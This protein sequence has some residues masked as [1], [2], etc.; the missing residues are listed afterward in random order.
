MRGR[1]RLI[2]VLLAGVLVGST[3]TLAVQSRGAQADRRSVA[4]A[5][6]ARSHPLRTFLAW[7]PGGL[8]EGFGRQAAGLANIQGVT[9]VAEDNIWLR[10][11]WSSY[12]AVVDAPR[13]PFAIPIDATGVDPESFA[14]FL[15]PADRGVAADLAQGEGVLGATSARLRGLGP[16][17]LLE[18]TTGVRVRIAA[19][20]PDEL[21][22]ASELLVSRRTGDAIGIRKDRYLFLQLRPGTHLSSGAMATSLQGLL[23]PSL[24]IDRRVRV[25]VPGDTPYLRAGDA[26]MPPV[27][28]K[29]LFGEF[30][31]RPV[32]GNP[33]YLQIQ[34]SWVRTHLATA[35][36]PLLGSVTCNRAIIP[37]LRGAMDELRRR[38]L[39]SLVKSNDG[40]FAPRFI[41][42]DPSAMIS[43]H[44]WGV[45]I[46]LNAATN[47]YGTP[48]DQ[49]P[50][51]VRIMKRWGF[52]WGGNFIVPDGNHFEYRRSPAG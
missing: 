33:G 20:L 24:G 46:D 37:Q 36:L 16:G 50:R 47:V 42:R 9:T 41:N 32:P 39:G 18:F 40:C 28:I 38:G 23:P 22:G 1:F 17:S 31:A 6:P 26:V 29:S 14:T 13:P 44:A 27:L 48:P 3:L 43:H 10:R 5:R 7:V 52:T 19:V 25:R 8:P 45:A 30:A 49:D 21:V 34:R 35:S 2:L 12:G 11:S 51:L 4:R 15:S